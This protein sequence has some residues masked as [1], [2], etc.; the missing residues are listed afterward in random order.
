MEPVGKS[1]LIEH[2]SGNTVGHT[3]YS[4]GREGLSDDTERITPLKEDFCYLMFPKR[5]GHTTPS[6]VEAQYHQGIR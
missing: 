3:L 1:K 2:K 5:R 4:K 6:A